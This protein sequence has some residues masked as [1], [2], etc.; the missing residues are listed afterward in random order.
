MDN[1]RH[2]AL[3]DFEIGEDFKKSASFSKFRRTRFRGIPT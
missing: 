3:A 1:N 2:I